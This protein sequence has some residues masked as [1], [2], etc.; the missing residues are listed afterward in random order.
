MS[1]DGLVWGAEPHLTVSFVP[2]GTGV[3]DQQSGLFARFNALGTTD[4]WQQAVTDAFQTWMV[5][6][7]GDVGRVAD[8]GQPLGTA[9]QTHADI[10]FGDVRVAAIDLPANVMALSIPG[11]AVSGT[12]VG[13]LLFNRNAAIQN[14]D[15]LF[16]VALHEAGNILGLPDNHDPNSPMSPGSIPVG[17]LPT[18]ADV[19]ALQELHGVRHVDLNDAVKPNEDTG[20]ATHLNFSE[21][22]GFDGSIPLIT[23]ADVTTPDDVDYYRLDN[24]TAYDGPITVRLRTNQLSSLAAQLTI[25]DRH[26]NTVADV[27]AGPGENATFQI[28][29][30]SEERYYIRAKAVGPGLHAV[31]GYALSVTYDGRLKSTPAE[32]DAYTDGRW[33]EL[34][35]TKIQ[36]LLMSQAGLKL[37]DDEVELDD[38][39]SGAGELKTQ[40]GFIESTRY[41]VAASLTSG[42][43]ADFY[44]FD[45]PKGQAGV[46]LVLTIRTE[47]WKDSQLS[48]LNLELLDSSGQVVPGVTLVRADGVGMYQ[49]VGVEPEQSYAVR[50][51][52]ASGSDAG[53]NY[54]LDLVFGDKAVDVIDV[55]HGM[56]TGEQPA[57]ADKLSVRGRPQ[58]VH[59]IGQN[60]SAEGPI[61]I[62]VR[63]QQGQAMLQFT[64]GPAETASANSILLL[65][66]EYLLQVE[67]PQVLNGPVPYVVRAIVVSDPLLVDAGDPTET[68]VTQCPQVE[69]QFCVPG[70]TDLDSDVD[71]QD[72][73]RLWLNFGLPVD[74]WSWGDF[75]GDGRVGWSDYFLLGN[76]Y[77]TQ[78]NLPKNQFQI[79]P[80]SHLNA[81]PFNPPASALYGDFDGDWDVDSA[82]MLQLLSGWSGADQPTTSPDFSAGDVDGDG[83]VDTSDVL[84]MLVNWSGA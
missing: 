16:A 40:D 1:V 46:P 30:A 53:G 55:A 81:S 8:G 6:T 45:S 68:P 83:D 23:Y 75:D 14:L 64:V 63:D 44:R 28:P 7:N 54:Q 59:F 79:A 41:N 67:S 10:R 32:L 3:M 76:Y 24:L 2:D 26:G 20:V 50:L 27:T 57:P 58:I 39:L 22:D 11:T 43:D 56:L 66:A 4:Q 69:G 31:G 9:G 19:A 18:A 78:T 61:V 21:E 15:E 37:L 35:Q 82:D 13:D 80:A 72:F 70:D 84:N 65:P 52:A 77:G 47:I 34:D 38:D 5:H 17:R 62:T 25:T 60:Q 73:D 12:W 51:G 71:Q 48:A 49:W 42:N 74:G 36:R 33:R 29:Q